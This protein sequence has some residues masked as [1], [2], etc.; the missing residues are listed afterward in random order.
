LLSRVF[1][2]RRNSAITYDNF[3]ALIELSETLS[4]MLFS[5]F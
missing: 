3:G 5:T 1:L 2:Q 4:F